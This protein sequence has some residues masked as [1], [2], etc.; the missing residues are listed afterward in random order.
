[1]TD[2]AT[3][4]RDFCARLAD[5]GDIILAPDVPDDPLIRSEGFRYLSR[6]A[7]LAL[8]ENGGAKL[9]HGGGGEVLLRAA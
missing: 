4:W 6:L 8:D 5:A 3:A 1:M 7:K 2:P 9:D